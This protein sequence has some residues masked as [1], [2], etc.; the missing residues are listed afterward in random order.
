MYPNEYKLIGTLRGTTLLQPAFGEVLVEGDVIE[1]ETHNV[2]QKN[3]VLSSKATVALDGTN[4]II[5]PS[6]INIGGSLE[7][8]LKLL[9]LFETATTLPSTTFIKVK[10]TNIPVIN[11]NDYAIPAN[12][13]ILF[14]L[15]DNKFYAY[16]S[17]GG[18]G[19]GT[20]PSPDVLELHSG[21]FNSLKEQVN[22]SVTK[23]GRVCTISIR[24]TAA[25]AQKT[26]SGNLLYKIWSSIPSKFAPSTKYPLIA[27][28][29]TFK[30]FTYAN[31][32]VAED[33][34]PLQPVR[35]WISPDGVEVEATQGVM[36]PL[37]F[38]FTYFTDG[39]V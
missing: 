31:A 3:G 9:L 28:E 14:V 32:Y 15:F 39:V 4:T 25:T 11:V 18:T 17:V 1:A 7:D 24:I 38:S 34:P 23:L 36:L 5:T 37:S 20:T 35:V 16:K 27:N 6:N 13:P 21:T 29:T 19:G 10:N 33:Y 22:Y 26:I 30:A 12:T 8:E 2:I